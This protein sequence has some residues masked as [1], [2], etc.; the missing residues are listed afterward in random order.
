MKAVNTFFSLF[1]SAIAGTEK[2]FTSGS[3]NRA[4]FLLSVPS[5]LELSMEALFVVVD[6]LFVSSLGERAITIVGIVNS[7]IIIFHSIAMGLSIAA[8]AIISRRVG[9]QRPREA[10][11][12]AMQAIYLGVGIAVLFSV[13]SVLFNRNILQLAGADAALLT[14]GHLFSRIM[15]GSIVLMI[16]RVLMNGVFRG[17]GN[18]AMAM[19]TLLL[20]NAINAVLC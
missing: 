7:V 1:R 9:E 4:T 20:S 12:A 13:L 19:R 6:L 17:A 15:F 11:Q 3:V 8:T 10:G 18:A 14:E 16:L 5:M 2:D